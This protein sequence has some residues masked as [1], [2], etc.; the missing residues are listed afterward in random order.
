MPTRF[1]V[2]QQ[3]QS[4]TE[5]SVVCCGFVAISFL[6]LVGFGL[7]QRTQAS[8]NILPDRQVPAAPTKIQPKLA[9]AL[10]SPVS[11]GPQASALPAPDVGQGGLV[12]LRG[13]TRPEAQAKNDRGRVPD[14]MTINHILLQLRRS[15]EQEQA[16]QQFINDLHDHTSPLFHHWLTAAEFGQRYGVPPADVARVT[17]WLESQGFEVNLVYPNQMVIDFTGSAGQIR[18]AF[19]TEIHHLLVNGQAHIANMSDPQ[20][21]AELTSTVAG[22]VSLNDFR[23]NSTFQRH[24]DYTL[25]SGGPWLVVPADLWMIYNFKPAFAAGYSGQGQTIVVVEDT[26]LYAP[27]SGDY[28][29]DWN[30]F[31]SALGLASAYPLGSLTQ[32]HPPPANNCADPGTTAGDDEAALDVEWASAGAPSATIELASCAD[33]ETTPGAFLAL[34]NLING[35]TPPAIISSSQGGSESAIGAAFNASINSLF[36]QAATE[37]TSVFVSAGDTGAASTDQLWEDHYYAEYGI[38]VSGLTS[39]PY[40]VSV[41]GTDFADS[42]EGTN[43]SYWSSTNNPA[44]YGSALSYIPEIPWNDSCASVL[45]GDYHGVLPTYGPGGMCYEAE[46]DLLSGTGHY[47]GLLSISAGGGGPSGCATGTPEYLGVVSGTCAGYPKPSWQSGFIGNPSDGVR[48][49]PDVSL[50][51]ANGYWGHAYVVCFSD[52]SNGGASCSGAPDTWGG[53]GGTS[54]AAPIWAAIQSLINQASGT[55]WGNPNP[56][57]YSRAATEYG[58]GGS[59]SCNSNLGN[60]VAS[61]CIFYDVTQIP[62]L[63]GGSGTG[64]DTDVPCNGVNCYLPSGT[65]ITGEPAIGVLSTSGE[66]YQPA[67]GAATGW[68]FAT[69]IGT[70]NVSNLVTSFISSSVASV[71]FSAPSLS[72]GNQPTSTTS[73]AQAE[74]VTNTGT[75][76]LIISTV[77]LGGTNASDFAKSADACTGATVTPNDTCTV[78]VTF[79]PSSASTENASLNFADNASNSPQTVPLSGTGTAPSVSLSTTSLGFSNQPVGTTSAASPLT[80]TNNGT[81]PL[82][83]TSI[84]VTGDFAIAASG[85]CSTSAPVAAGS[86]CVINATFTP[87]ATG[88]RTGSLTLTDN[89]SGSPQ[90]VGLSGTGTAPSVSL[91]T[92]SVSFGNQPVGTPSAASPVTVTNNGT[93][94]L[95]IST[96]TISGAHANDFAKSA[97]T[98]TGATVIPNNT[99]MVSVTFTPSLVGSESASLNFTDN[100]S[101]SPQMVPLSGTGASP[102][103]GWQLEPGA[104]SQVSVGSDGTVWGINGAGQ[105]YMFNPQTQTWQQAPGLFSQIAVGASGFVWALNAAGQIYRYDPTLQSWDRIPGVLSQIAVGSDGDVWGI[106]SSAQVYHFNSA[107]ETWS[108]IP[109]ALAQIAVGY[110]GAVWGI[111]AAQQIYRFNPG[112]QNWQQIPGALKQIAVGADGD[113]WGINNAG[114]TYHFN[115]LTQRWNNTPGSLAQIAVGSAS[116]VWGID[117]A[118]AIWRFNAQA[119]AWN[120]IPGQLAQIGVGANGAVWGVNSANQIYQFVQPTQPTQSF[121]QV[122]GSLAQISAGLEGEAWGIDAAQQIWRYDPQRQSLEQIPGAL[123]EIR[124]GF[125]GNVWGLNAAGQISQFNPATQTW[126]QIPGSLAQLAVGA[127]GSVW[128][129]DSAEQIWRFNPSTQAFEQIPGRLAQLAVGADGTVWGINSVGLIYRFNPATQGWVQI[130]GSLTQIAVGSANNVW[131]LN[132]AGQIWRYDPLL[133]K[134]D[135]IPGG[136]ASI[137][138]AF[139][140]TVWGLNS[141]NQ[142]WRFNAQKQGWD[143]IPGALAQ[144]S[145][146]ADAVV[147][148]LNAG[149]QIYEYW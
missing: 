120:Q 7:L 12:T 43:A 71:S 115:S 78:S 113:V 104:L 17:D 46:Y 87:T 28:A 29:A 122:T 61:T 146:G 106:N 100:A 147:W 66:T 116:N 59:T 55:K 121:H 145:V 22:V 47:G 3:R 57:Y 34:Q 77:T 72:F 54:F 27:T 19:H 63:Y 110:D 56:E 88:S 60:T 82:N 21:P 20:I 33:T 62:L 114:Q 26:D 23:L 101:N 2:T 70:V 25:A 90:V 36:Q 127:D 95:I 93:G 123:N 148:G 112:T 84:A 11:A 52:P 14:D 98:C 81:A 64:G 143:S 24:A 124:V 58:A 119:Q 44:N 79:T 129:I 96:V 94:N 107:T 85:T 133:Q 128:G 48:D 139:D 125:G 149:G 86:N 73:P 137:A 38:T 103:S 76:N 45:I 144:V 8:E 75:A 89:A 39:T 99:C 91:S 35:G 41:G 102:P 51:A 37:G 108:Y 32:V 142:I 140:G 6:A 40:N 67:F 65:Y 30:S 131:G 5:R 130:P 105:A 53:G 109:G 138:V 50:F 136:L 18:Q 10:A 69:G 92:T 16:L 9:A 68:D 1:S 13:N 135:S 42:Y 31:R 97:D 4:A 74:T 118:G 49:I 15:P 83:F 132:A 134:W 126:N 117:A 80:V 141:A 111:N